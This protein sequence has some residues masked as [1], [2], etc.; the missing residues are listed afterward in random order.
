MSEAIKEFNQELLEI[1]AC[2]NCQGDLVYDQANQELIC[3]QSHLAY[4]IKN[5][6]AILLIDQA[7]KI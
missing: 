6:I 1:L 3:N 5:G 7:R 2:P 4:P